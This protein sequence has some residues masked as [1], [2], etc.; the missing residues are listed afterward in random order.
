MTV[1]L[2]LCRVDDRVA[3][4]ARWTGVLLILLLVGCATGPNANPR[5]PLEP[6]N[7]GVFKFNDAVDAAILKPVATVYR[8]VTPVRVRQGI[9]NFF[10][11]LQDVWSFVNNAL[12]LKGQAAIDSLK[13]FGVNT[14]VGWAG[15]FDVATEMD[16]EKHTKDFG[17]TL[18]YWGVAPGPYLVLP[19]LGPST[20]RDTVALP[21]DLKGDIVSNIGHIPTRT[22]AT[23]VRAIDSR[24]DL[25]KTTTMLEE[26][27]LDRYTFTRD[28]FLQRRRNTIYDGNPPEE[29]TAGIGPAQQEPAQ[30]RDETEMPTETLSNSGLTGNEKVKP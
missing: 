20:L 11:N 30:S 14:F 22:T 9:G 16:I 6:F 5:D 8:D 21:V 25:L 3:G 23:V 24:S 27:A 10:G 17:H 2:R 15:V 12:Q 13:R 28:A 19:L 4:G 29:E 26:A 7:R 1:N 18:G